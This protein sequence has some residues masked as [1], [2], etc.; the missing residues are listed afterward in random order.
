ME[1]KGKFIWIVFSI[2]MKF[3]IVLDHKIVT[4]HFFNFFFLYIL[5]Y[6]FV[7]IWHNIMGLGNYKEGL[8]RSSLIEML[9]SALGLTVL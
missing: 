1:K 9:R 6:F 8:E 5:I 4:G 7:C 2:A 3:L